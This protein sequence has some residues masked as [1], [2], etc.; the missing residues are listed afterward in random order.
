MR[1][2]TFGSTLLV[3][4]VASIAAT[5]CL[6]GEPS[7]PSATESSLGN[8]TDPSAEVQATPGQLVD[9]MLGLAAHPEENMNSSDR[10]A[11]ATALAKMGPAT[12]TPLIQY[13][14][15]SEVPQISRLFVLQ[16]IYPHL[17]PN[18]FD[19]LQELVQSEDDSVRVLGVAAVGYLD[20]DR[21][22]DLLK[23]LKDDDLEQVRMAALS[24]LAMNGDA[25]ARDELISL[26]WDPAQIAP[27][28]SDRVRIEVVR[29]L[30]VN[31]TEDDI[32]VLVDAMDE[33]Y[34]ATF[35]RAGIA[36]V[37]GR[38]GDESH[39]AV[40][41]QSLA[42]EEAEEYAKIVEEAVH[43]IEERAAA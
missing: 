30:L 29:V 42:L 3:L 41:E 9:L 1:S 22:I 2:F 14:G 33:E 25:A 26:Y 20:D 21:V 10:Y 5:G 38:M 32:P 43:A 27:I 31:P 39:L 11:I 12:L 15:D 16:S 19:Q 7:A 23:P 28:S 4:T 34:I 17:T 24:G 35:H 37:L 18:Y 8:S 36:E 6:P 13:M 40:L